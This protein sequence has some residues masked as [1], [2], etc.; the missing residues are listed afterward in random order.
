M[1][2]CILRNQGAHISFAFSKHKNK[3]KSPITHPKLIF[4]FR[5]LLMKTKVRIFSSLIVVTDHI[6]TGM[7]D[8]K[9]TGTVFFDLRKAFTTVSHDLLLTKLHNL[10]IRDVEITWFT[11]YL[12]EHKQAIAL[13]GILSDQNC[14]TIAV[15]EGSTFGPLLFSIYVNDLSKNLTCI[16]VLYAN[17]TALTYSSDE[18]NDISEKINNNLSNVGIWLR[19]NKLSLNRY[20]TRLFFETYLT[21]GGGVVATSNKFSIIRVL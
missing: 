17:D 16:T 3:P 2:A 18:A 5:I 13:R 19:S 6:L 14:I 8:G 1:H 7:D 9:V 4:F 10:C 20:L 12:K 11:S 15:P 21:G